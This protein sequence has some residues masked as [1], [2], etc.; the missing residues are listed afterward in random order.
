MQQQTSTP[1]RPPTNN[2][3]KSTLS[4]DSMELGLGIDMSPN[5]QNENGTT[6]SKT[7]KRALDAREKAEAAIKRPNVEQQNVNTNN[8]RIVYI[9][10]EGERPRLANF[11]NAMIKLTNQRDPGSVR[12]MPMRNGFSIEAKNKEASKLLTPQN[13]IQEFQKYKVKVN[14]NNNKSREKVTPCFVITKVLLDVSLNTIKEQLNEQ[15]IKSEKIYRVKSSVTNQETRL[16]RVLTKDENQA[17][18]AI[19]GGVVLCPQ[20]FKCEPSKQQPK[21]VQCFKCQAHGHIAA[22]CDNLQRCPNCGGHHHV[23]DRYQNE[24]CCANCNEKHSAAYKICQKY[25]EAK[26]K[27]PAASY[28]EALKTKPENTNQNQFRKHAIESHYQTRKQN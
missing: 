5:P 20:K 13:I 26:L 1:F 15:G 8:Q 17:K 24:P 27:A 25:K 9:N 11:A 21:V 2:T 19:K 14:S 12:E 3:Y 16:V 4:D 10:F 23:K 6:F 7:R 18:K 28:A 22:N